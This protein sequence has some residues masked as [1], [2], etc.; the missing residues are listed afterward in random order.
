VLFT[1]LLF[2]HLFLFLNTSKQIIVL[3][4]LIYLNIYGEIKMEEKSFDVVIE[5]DN[6]TKQYFASVPVLPGC[7]TYAETLSELLI[8]IK[9]AIEL[10]LETISETPNFQ[11]N[12]VL[13][14]V[15]ITV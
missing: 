1:F 10:H 9:E 8:N 11:K 6:D 12:K 2:C 4:N 5:M 14:L 15:K 3:L 13:G 7:Y